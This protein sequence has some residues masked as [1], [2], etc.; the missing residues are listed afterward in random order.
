M[1]DELLEL[2]VVLNHLA[3]PSFKIMQERAFVL[4]LTFGFLEKIDAIL[5]GT[6]AAFQSRRRVEVALLAGVAHSQA[7]ETFECDGHVD[8]CLIPNVDCAL[9]LL[10]IIILGEIVDKNPL[11]FPILAKESR[12]LQNVLLTIFLGQTDHVEEVWDHHAELLEL[13]KLGL[14]VQSNL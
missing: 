4:G 5:G 6:E 11:D 8:G 9:A 13:Q 7:V 14:V 3:S 12:E 10:V 1:A 2:D